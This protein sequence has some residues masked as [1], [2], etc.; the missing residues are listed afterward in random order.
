MK[1]PESI[2]PD[3]CK[4]CGRQGI[5]ATRNGPTCKHAKFQWPNNFAAMTEQQ[6]VDWLWANRTKEK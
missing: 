2:K 5:I 1:P 4:E 3:F 6:R